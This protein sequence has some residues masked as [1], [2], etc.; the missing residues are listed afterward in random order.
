[1]CIVVTGIEMHTVRMAEQCRPPAEQGC[2]GTSESRKGWVSTNQTLR[3]GGDWELLEGGVA[4]YPGGKSW[5][6]GSNNRRGW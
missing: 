4:A 6:Q 1:M 2:K 3:P 5:T